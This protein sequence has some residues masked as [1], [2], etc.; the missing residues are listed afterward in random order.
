M[1]GAWDI[2]KG[3]F[4]TLLQEVGKRTEEIFLGPYAVVAGKVV[5]NEIW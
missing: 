5:G 1:I 3:V 2:V 4:I